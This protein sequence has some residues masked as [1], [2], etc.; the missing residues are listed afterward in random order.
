[1]SIVKVRA[2]LETALAAMT[3][4]IATA[5]ENASFTPP[6]SSVPYQAAYLLPATPDNDEYGSSHRERGIFQISLYYPLQAGP[7][8]AATRAELLRST[9][10]RGASFTKDG[11]TVSITHTPDVGTGTPD[12]DRWFVPVKCRFVSNI[13]A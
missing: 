5:Y 3:P 12:G 13:I 11:V 6:A 8:A 2:A 9:F 10:K 7:S 1:M 4:A